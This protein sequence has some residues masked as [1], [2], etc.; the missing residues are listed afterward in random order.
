MAARQ[1]KEELLELL[2]ERQRRIEQHKILTYFPDTGP[3]RREL[4]RKHLEFFGAGLNHRIRLFLAANRVGKTESAGGYEVTCHLTGEYPA[5]WMGRR[6]S[7]PVK[8][9]AAGDTRQTTRD[10]QQF[11]LL[12]PPNNHGSGLI[13]GKLLIKTTPKPGVP[14]A[15]ETVTVKHKSGGVSTLGFRSYDQGRKAFQGTEQDVIW[16]DEECPEDIY[17]E[18][19][20]RTMTTQGMVVLTFTPLLG[21]TPLVLGFLPGGKLEESSVGER[22]VV[23]AT[24]DDVPHLSESDKAALLAEFPPHQRDAR[25][26][27]V[28]QLGSGAIYPVSESD[29]VIAPFALP[30]YWPRVYALDVGWNRTAGIW[31]AHD[32]ET[33]TLYLYSEHYRGQA[34]PAIHASAIKARGAWIP[35]VIDPA[36]RGRS[37]EDGKQLLAQYLAEGLDLTTAK[38]A[39]EAGIYEVWQRLSTGR[40]KVFAS[41]GNWL[42]E[43]RLY[44]RDEKGRIVKEGDHLMDCIR[45]LC[46]SGIERAIVQAPERITQVN[47]MGDSACAY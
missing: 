3:L 29:F 34:E 27:G 44:R 35:G 32:R 33:D 25:S 47:Y 14:D 6:F 23:M 46:M 42:Q 40:L 28:P 30:A 1:N 22:A 7:G 39:V 24:W 5:W 36:S 31:A 10:I 19:L 4:Y 43:F 8:A 15:V 9:W 18:C 2:E 16:L 45:Y 20:V 11:K 41:L 13:P 21:L 17:Q 12:G 26:K 37:Q 38:N